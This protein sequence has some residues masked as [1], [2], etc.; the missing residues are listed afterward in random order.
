MIDIS[1]INILHIVKGIDIGGHSGGAEY[2]GIRLVRA[3]KKLDIKITLCAFL[4]YG[5]AV[6]QQWFY[7]LQNEGIE[8]FYASSS[9]KANFCEAR[10]NINKWIHERSIKIV[11]SHYQVGTI[12]CLSLKLNNRYDFLLRTAHANLEFGNSISG[13]ISRIVF[14]DFLFPLFLNYE[15]GV[16]KTITASLNKQVIRRL[17]HKP[18]HWI[19]NAIPDSS[20]IEELD[21]PLSKFLTSCRL[22]HRG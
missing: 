7:Q 12:T 2:F 10:K 11:H 8:V 4:K 22:S 18:A 13:S 15:I 3:L 21:D 20:E 5:T 17:L 19:P 6:E 14:R 16:S 1:G 9:D